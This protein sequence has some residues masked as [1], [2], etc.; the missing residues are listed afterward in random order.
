MNSGRDLPCQYEQRT[1]TALTSHWRNK[2]EQ[3]DRPIV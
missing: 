1:G 2:N 3:I